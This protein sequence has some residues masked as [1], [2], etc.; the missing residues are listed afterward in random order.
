MNTAIDTPVA[1]G[2]PRVYLPLKHALDRL[3]GFFGLVLLSPLLLW[4]AWRIRREGGGPALFKQTRAG[5]HGR[6][7]TVYKFRT[8]RMDADPY[9]D[10][11]QTGEDPRI[12]RTGR[13]LREKSLDELPQLI[14]VLR[15][16][17]SLVGPRPLYVQQMAEWDAR[18][19]ARLLVKP[20]LTGLAQINGRGALTI[21]QKLEWDVRYVEAVGPWLDLRILWRTIRGAGIREGIYEVRY[22]EK[23]ERRTGK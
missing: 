5:R 10:S 22:S 13:W 9:G 23:L 7:F 1:C 3:A 2:A 21:E 17:M 19:R 14:N 16:E 8:M 15:G 4:I 6:P 12:T 20:G 11:P 18:Q